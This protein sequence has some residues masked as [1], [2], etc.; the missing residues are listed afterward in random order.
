VTVLIISHSTIV[1]SLVK[2]FKYFK[3]KNYLIND[4]IKRGFGKLEQKTKHCS[5]SEIYLEP[6]G[7]EEILRV[8]SD[9]KHL[10]EIEIG[11][12]LEYRSCLDRRITL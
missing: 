12:D 6:E 11:M 1:S 10:S 5:F 2:Y 8:G 9:C 7:P 3:Y 4:R